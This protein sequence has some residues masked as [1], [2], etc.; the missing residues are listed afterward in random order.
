MSDAETADMAATMQ[1]VGDVLM[2]GPVSAII[3]AHARELVRIVAAELPD[4]R[5]VRVTVPASLMTNVAR[6]NV[7]VI[8]NT[9]LRRALAA[10]G[11]RVYAMPDAR[12]QELEAAREL[13]R[14]AF[15]GA[16]TVTVRHNDHWRGSRR[17]PLPAG[18][19]GFVVDATGIAAPPP[20]SGVVRETLPLTVASFVV[21]GDADLGDKEVNE[22]ICAACYKTAPTMP[23]C[24]RCKRSRYCSVACQRAQWKKHKKNCTERILEASQA[25]LQ[26]HMDD[27]SSMPELVAPPYPWPAP[28]MRGEPGRA[29]ETQ[30][31]YQARLFASSEF[32]HAIKLIP[33]VE[34]TRLERIARQRQ[35]ETNG[36]F[37]T[38]EQLRSLVG[39]CR[40]SNSICCHCVSRTVPQCRLR[41]CAA[42]HLSFYCSRSCQERD[43]PRHSLWCCRHDG[44]ADTGPLAM[45]VTQVPP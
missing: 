40:V 44:D 34:V 17:P 28:S 16:L 35:P 9:L 25:T 39:W 3:R 10:Y 12:E 26:Q 42:C 22:Y 24:G 37:D 30:E 13:P 27:V 5:V 2:S 21:G 23:A 32:Q 41:V 38:A 31:A 1:R 15:F 19:T 43:W 7:F 14:A 4:N 20:P 29:I 6:E 36:P 18:A 8:V 45:A 11:G 33:V